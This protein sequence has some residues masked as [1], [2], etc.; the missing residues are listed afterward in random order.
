[1]DSVVKPSMDGRWSA[2]KTHALTKNGLAVSSV[3]AKERQLAT[4]S[5]GDKPKRAPKVLEKAD[6]LMSMRRIVAKNLK[7]MFDCGPA[8]G[9]Y[10]ALAEATGLGINTIKRVL[11]AKASPTLDT[12]YLLAGAHGLP[13]TKLFDGINER[14]SHMLGMFAKM[15]E[16][17]ERL[18]AKS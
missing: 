7:A 15:Q 10:A 4:T 13:I 1:M 14:D 9:N 8:R 5:A 17:M 2:P 6:E 12:L 18:E 11:A 16:T 3:M